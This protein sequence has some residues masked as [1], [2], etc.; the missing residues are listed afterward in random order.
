MFGNEKKK[1]C[2]VSNWFFSLRRQPRKQSSFESKKLTQKSCVDLTASD[3]TAA[4]SEQDLIFTKKPSRIK[5]KNNY[6]KRNYININNNNNTNNSNYDVSS[7]T[8]NSY[9]YCCCKLSSKTSASMLANDM[10]QLSRSRVANKKNYNNSLENSDDDGDPDIL[11]YS[12]T[13]RPTHDLSS[14]ILLYNKEEEFNRTTHTKSTKNV[15]KITI[16]CNQSHTFTRNTGQQVCLVYSNNN[17][18]ENPNN[19]NIL[20]K[21]RD[22]LILNESGR[23]PH[24]D[25][26]NDL[27]SSLTPISILDDTIE[28]IDSSTQN[29]DIHYRANMEHKFNNSQ[30]RSSNINY[31]CGSNMT[32]DN[33]QLCCKKYW[34]YI[35]KQVI[36][37]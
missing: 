35:E 18:L 31:N 23:V 37:Y 7:S 14:N 24:A 4:A 20:T 8:N 36:F 26:T 25:N 1:S 33:S 6:E 29:S 9:T 19:H 21:N 22:G 11:V 15:T 13:K 5:L 30:N 10:D 12:L 17:E 3:I 28:Y 34:D 27:L 16:N 2:K 32:L